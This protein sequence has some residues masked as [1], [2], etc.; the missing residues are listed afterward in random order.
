MFNSNFRGYALSIAVICVL[1][2]AC[3]GIKPIPS[4]GVAAG[5][6][7]NDTFG[8]LL[9]SDLNGSYGALDYPQEVHQV[10]S[11][12]ET[13]R[14]DMLLCAGD[15]I[16]GQ[17][18]SLSRSR[19]DSMWSSFDRQILSRVDS[20]GIPFGFT[21][22]N[23]DASPGFPQDRSAAQ[24]FWKSRRPHNRLNIING[25]HYPF[26]FSYVQEGVFFIS[27]DAAGAEI[28]SEVKQW[29]QKEL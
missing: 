18:S 11:R 14:P 22:G 13:L 19:L 10:I 3:A 17:K 28:P 6:D 15:M 26:Y 21:L 24:A 16:A 23:H 4:G 9:I 8:M 27:W 2:M 1:C 5:S 29:M 20:L 7:T 25:K 12:L